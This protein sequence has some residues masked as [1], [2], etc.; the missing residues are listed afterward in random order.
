MSK[1]N[2]LLIYPTIIGEIPNCIAQLASVY[3][4]E[5]YNVA[6]AINT[7]KKPLTNEDFIKAAQECEADH[8]AISTLTYEMQNTY[9][10]IKSFKDLGYKVLV[11]GPHATTNPEEVVRFGADIVVR[12]E[13]EETLKEILKFWRG[14]DLNI[15]KEVLKK[16][17]TQKTD[18]GLKVPEILSDGASEGLGSILGITYF[19]KV[20]KKIKSTP[21]RK[22][23]SDLSSLPKPNYDVFDHSVF[24]DQDGMIRGTNR[25]FTSR[26]CPA[27]CTFCDWGVFGQRVTFQNI[28]KII[29]EMQRRVD[30]YGTT[31]FKIADDVFT[32]NKKHV[33]T[34]CKEVVKITPRVEWQAQTRA[35]FATP[36]MMKMM[37]EAGCYLVNFGLE[38]GDQETLTRMDKM[39]TVEQNN[40]APKMA[41]A[42]GLKVHANFM[43]GFPWET[44]K[45]IDNT[46]KLAY[47]IWDDVFLFQV[48]GSL[49][50]FPGT[51]VYDQYVKDFPQFK[52][53]W[54]KDGFQQ[55]GIQT[56]QNNANPYSV[57]TYYQRNLFDDSFIQNE[58][59]FT[60]NKEFKKKASEFVFE[61]G[62]HNLENIYPNQKIKQKILLNIS[63][64][65]YFTY[66]IFPNLEKNIGGALY[67]I[68]KFLRPKGKRATAE[69]VRSMRRGFGKVSQTE[70]VSK[71]MAKS[72]SKAN[73]L[74]YENWV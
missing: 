65:S 47:E 48:S 37:K 63:K 28:P 19:D 8:I 43:I 15:D 32:V 17:W 40:E 29:A 16:K 36:E 1:N 38:S 26:G 68:F 20:E 62:R 57:S 34:F 12:N 61:I 14:E 24:S 13:G 22:R 66:K 53:Y 45:H 70:F 27:K 11:G 9:K 74:S 60:Y 10:L 71:R 67:S 30:T 41:A 69:H 35:E 3:E 49:V 39:C 42:S 59:F 52:D 51:R 44:P 54:L 21:A 6:T 5:G 31:N 7:F 64:I 56:Y 4:D 58:T 2:V 23:I 33:E 55:F 18:M 25:I 46:L 72:Q 50:P 73:Q